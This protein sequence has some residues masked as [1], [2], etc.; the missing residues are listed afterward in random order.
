MKRNSYPDTMFLRVSKFIALQPKLV[1]EIQIEN[2]ELGI[3]KHLHTQKK[4]IS[5]TPEEQYH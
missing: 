5:R 4:I 2:T 3:F 1:K